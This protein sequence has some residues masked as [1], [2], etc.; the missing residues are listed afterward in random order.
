MRDRA[1]KRRTLLARA[2]WGLALA[3][4][5]AGLGV[6]CSYVFLRKERSGTRAAPLVHGSPDEITSVAVGPE[7]NL[8][9]AGGFGVKV[10]GPDGR[11]IVHWKTRGPVR[12]LAVDEKGNVYAAYATRV[13]KF[14]PE[15]E[16]LLIWGKG[17]CGGEGFILVSGLAASGGNIFV[18]DAGGRLVYRFTD[19]G[20]FL[21]TIGG[22][23]KDPDGIGLVAPS[24][25]I[26]CAAAGDALL[27]CN[28]GRKRVERYDFEGNLIGFWGKSGSKDDEFPGCCNP[29]NIALMPD[30]RVVVSQ[31][32]IPRVKVFTPDGGFL[33]AFGGGVFPQGCRGIDLAVDGRGRI[34][35]VDRVAA[36]LRVFEMSG[37]NGRE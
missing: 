8:Y 31:K 27:V 16:R 23:E 21:N 17:G 29:T 28:L 36:R 34:H 7:D 30:G 33:A 1:Q 10:S 26:D 25:Y 4:V 3:G 14:S 5:L 6:L 22:K 20:R 18:A 11:R 15:G 35:A 9:V 24:P 37:E 13:E 19:D 2:W 12:A 32:G